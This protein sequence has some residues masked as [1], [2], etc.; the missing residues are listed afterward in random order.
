MFGLASVD[1][2]ERMNSDF[3]MQAT[4]FTVTVANAWAGKAYF[5]IAL[6]LLS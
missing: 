1:C 4:S 2:F 5:R 3:I 6:P